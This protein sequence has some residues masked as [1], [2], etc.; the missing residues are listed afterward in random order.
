MKKH[1]RFARIVVAVWCA[2]SFVVFYLVALRAGATE[3]ARMFNEYVPTTYDRVLDAVAL[4]L[5][6]PA[7][8]IMSRFSDFLPHSNAW[9]ILAPLIF[10]GCVV[11]IV[12]LL[13]SVVFDKFENRKRN[14]RDDIK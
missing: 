11:G 7:A 13:F 3:H 9:F 2:A 4:V 6:A 1:L 12:A 8:F 10:N 5:F 14:I